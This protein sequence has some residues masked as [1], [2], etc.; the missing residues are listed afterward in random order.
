MN[1]HNSHAF[2]LS[3]AFMLS[4]F[5]HVQ[6][7][8]ILWHVAFQASLSM[9]FSRQEYWSRLPCPSPR[10]LPNAGIEP[11]SLALQAVSLP[12]EPP[13]IKLI[14]HEKKKSL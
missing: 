4:C 11:R 14:L 9:G 12:T 10:Y 1:L 3:L 7:C 2:K 8:A 13:G 5:S 6:L